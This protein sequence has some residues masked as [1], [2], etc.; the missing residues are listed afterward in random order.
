MPVLPM[1]DFIQQS[2]MEASGWG[3]SSVNYDLSAL[4]A[5]ATRATH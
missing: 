5:R 2:F 4:L 1:N 3:V